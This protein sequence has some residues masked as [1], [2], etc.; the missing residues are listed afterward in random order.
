MTKCNKVRD[1]AATISNIFRGYTPDLIAGD[2]KSL[3][4]LPQHGLRP[5]ARALC[6][7]G[8]AVP[9]A[10]EFP[11][12]SGIWLK[13]WYFV[14]RKGTS[15]CSF[16]LG[17]THFQQQSSTGPG[18]DSAGSKSDPEFQNSLHIQRSTTRANNQQHQ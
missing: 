7:L 13:H 8:S 14:T 12:T 4:S 2:G 11:Q 10:Y 6:V 18:S 3:P 5:P 16:L 9:L 1:F 15:Y 17:S